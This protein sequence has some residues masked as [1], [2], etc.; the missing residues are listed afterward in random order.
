MTHSFCLQQGMYLCWYMCGCLVIFDEGCL[1]S[2]KWAPHCSGGR[3]AVPFGSVLPMVGTQVPIQRFQSITL[4]KRN[5]SQL[6]LK[7]KS[8]PSYETHF[9]FHFDNGIYFKHLPEI[10]FIRQLFLK[11][12]CIDIGVRKD[13][14]LSHLIPRNLSFTFS[15]KKKK[16]VPSWT[17]WCLCHKNK[18]RR[19]SEWRCPPPS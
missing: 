16:R 8:P 13:M 11:K 6:T 10:N 3:P 7:I 4:R 15:K 14:P 9:I 5:L 1:A 2:R 18:P 19:L 17:P 12:L